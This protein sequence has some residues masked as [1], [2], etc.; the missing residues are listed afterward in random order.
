MMIVTGATGHLG[1]AIIETLVK[2]MPASEVGATCRD[3]D[4]A[5]D[6][7]ARGVRVRQGDFGKP[8]DLL[9]AFE[10]ATR[11]LIVSSNARAQGGDPIAQHGNAIHAARNAGVSRIVYTSQMAA[12]ADSAFPPMHDH[13]ATERL[14]AESGLP[15]TALRHGFY[16]DSGIAMMGDAFE[17]GE[18]E[19]AADGKFSWVAHA[20][21]AE[22]A[23]ILLTD[24]TARYEGPTPPLT[25][26]EALDFGDLAAIASGLQGTPIRR[27][28][29]SDDEM[30]ARMKAR[31]AQD[32]AADMVLGLFSGARNGEW[33]TVDP[34]LEQLLG[35]APIPMK[36]LLSAHALVKPK[37]RA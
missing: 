28:I 33:A 1:R 9:H 8:E 25:G 12:S 11:L 3:P 22:A 2:R 21:L 10:G 34:T 15:W 32:R 17:T 5:A 16:A 7:Q 35:R 36:D 19:T 24:D 37:A 23:A 13:A 26:S 4:K 14:L 20:D 18:L 31:G 27:K 30:R 29:L 6:L